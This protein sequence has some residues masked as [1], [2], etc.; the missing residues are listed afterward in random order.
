MI[1]RV[2]RHIEIIVLL[3]ARAG[4]KAVQFVPHVFVDRYNGV[5]V[6]CMRK[7][8]VPGCLEWPVN[9]QLLKRRLFFFGYQPQY[10]G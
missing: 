4:Q 1:A 2:Q 6:Q 8:S 9:M 3:T 7:Y 10:F 5:N